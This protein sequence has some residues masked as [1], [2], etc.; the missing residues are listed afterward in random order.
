MT[1]PDAVAQRVRTWA[2]QQAE[3]AGLPDDAS[4]ELFRVT[5]IP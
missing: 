3:V 1:D 5:N 4:A 2:R